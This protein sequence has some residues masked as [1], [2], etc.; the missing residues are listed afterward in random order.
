MGNRGR[1]PVG[2]CQSCW[3]AATA[4]AQSTDHLPQPPSEILYPALLLPPD[5]EAWEPPPLSGAC[6]RVA[7]SPQVAQGQELLLWLLWL[8]Q[9]GLALLLPWCPLWLGSVARGGQGRAD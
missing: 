1:R 6:A 4:P 2:L 3:K 7:C 9:L 5:V 8:A